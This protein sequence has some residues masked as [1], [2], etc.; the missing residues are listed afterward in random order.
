MINKV[1]NLDIT[2]GLDMDSDMVMDVVKEL[3][4]IIADDQILL[5]VPMKDY[6]SM[7]VGG[8]AKVLVLPSTVSEIAE[9]IKLLNNYII[10]YYVIGN[11]TNLI[12]SDYGYNGVIIK[13]SD[14][15]SSMTVDGN[16]ITSRSG[17]SIVS[18]SNLACENSLSGLEFAAGIPGTVGGAVVMNAG[19]YDGE[20]KDVVFETTCIDNAAGIVRLGCEDMQFGYRTSRMQKENLIVLEVK[21]RLREGNK[22]EIRSKMKELNRRRR[23][24]QPLNYPSSGSIFK[25]PAGHY[26]GKLIEDAGLKGYRI[27]GAQV[28]DKHCGFIINTGTATASD[29][30]ELI[31]LVKRRVFETSGVILHQ[32]V[33]IL[34]G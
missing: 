20:M 31:E 2:E 1:G 4:R 10:P 19:A 9:I 29:V 23:E 16:V 7:R 21:M 32:E 5:D 11:G 26:A 13:L 12:F 24:K 17:A 8:N 25:R 30:I 6:T 33:K 22:D 18:V 28:S 34:G 15:F 27:G 14:N 3:N